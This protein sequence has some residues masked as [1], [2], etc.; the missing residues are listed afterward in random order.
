MSFFYRFPGQMVLEGGGDGHQIPEN[1]ITWTGETDIPPGSST[2][3]DYKMYKI[4]H[5][6][7]GLKNKF[8]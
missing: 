1:R 8:V 3:W 6:F 2:G 7:Y 5:V 4:Y